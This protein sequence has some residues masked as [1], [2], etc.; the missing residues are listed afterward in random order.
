[1]AGSAHTFAHAALA[2][3]PP[4]QNPLAR[5][6][7]SAILNMALPGRI[8]FCAAALRPASG[9]ISLL[10]RVR[11]RCVSMTR[12]PAPRLPATGNQIVGEIFWRCFQLRLF[13]TPTSLAG[14][15]VLPSKSDF[16]PPLGKCQVPTHFRVPSSLAW[17]RPLP[18]D[19]G[20]CGRISYKAI[21]PTG[22]IQHKKP[23]KSRTAGLQKARLQLPPFKRV[24]QFGEVKGKT[25]WR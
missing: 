11:A 1:M 15:C 2:S 21:C 20:S 18:K 6:R 25:L 5:E 14:D 12:A 22:H 19:G 17:R 7:P 16:W 9:T 3:V 10:S 4:N 13:A 24:S 8:Y 23:G